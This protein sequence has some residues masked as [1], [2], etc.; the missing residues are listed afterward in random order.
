MTNRKLVCDLDDSSHEL[1]EL[2]REGERRLKKKSDQ[3]LLWQ[4][5]ADFIAEGEAVCGPLFQPGAISERRQQLEA[6]LERHLLT[7]ITGY[8]HQVG[9]LVKEAARRTGNPNG[10][11][12]A[13]EAA[14][15]M[16][17]QENGSLKRDALLASLNR[18]YAQG[19]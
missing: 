16:I 4:V 14:W 15:S 13:R 19:V 8:A 12:T 5:V 1:G 18:A 10:Q 2:A 9:Q 17:K 6:I 7:D 11:D 3:D